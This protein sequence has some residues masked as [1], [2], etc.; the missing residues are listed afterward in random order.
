M[1]ISYY[2]G[3]WSYCG[4][5]YWTTKQLCAKF[6]HI[7]KLNISSDGLGTRLICE[8]NQITLNIENKDMGIMVEIAHLMYKI[9]RLYINVELPERVLQILKS[10]TE[11]Y[12]YNADLAKGKM[13]YSR[14]NRIHWVENGTYKDT[15]DGEINNIITDP[16]FDDV[17]KIRPSS[18]SS[19]QIITKS[20]GTKI[21]F[22]VDHNNDHP[23]ARIV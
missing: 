18:I 17:S 10:K 6:C 16:L 11:K 8:V 19:Y 12:N 7:G 3:F 4:A 5:S 9:G 21:E 22:V 14:L 20:D 15:F 1:S 13:M 23:Y 2:K